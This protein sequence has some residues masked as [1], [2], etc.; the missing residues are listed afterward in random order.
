MLKIVVLG[1]EDPLPRLARH[2]PILVY[3]AIDKAR[4]WP[5]VSPA[6]EGKA[7][8]QQTNLRLRSSN[9][10]GNCNIKK[11]P[12]D[13]PKAVFLLISDEAERLCKFSC[14]SLQGLEGA[15]AEDHHLSA[16]AVLVEVSFLAS[17]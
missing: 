2:F 8:L 7:V 1:C 6:R 17:F 16:D 4:Y 15:S 3:T 14:F 12:E 11:L 5:V 10:A 13:F 9:Y